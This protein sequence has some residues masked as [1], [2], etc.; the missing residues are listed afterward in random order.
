MFCLLRGHLRYNKAAYKKPTLP[1]SIFAFVP[2]CFLALLPLSR[3]SQVSSLASAGCAKRLQFLGFSDA[4]GHP[5]VSRRDAERNP[6]MPS[7]TQGCL[8]QL[9]D[10]SRHPWV[11]SIPEFHSGLPPSIPGFQ[12]SLGFTQGCLQAS[13]ASR[14]ASRHPSTHG[15]PQGCRQASLTSL[16]PRM[17][18]G[19]PPGIPGFQ[20]CLRASLFFFFLVFLVF[21]CSLISPPSYYPMF[22][23]VC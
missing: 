22:E 10:A 2:C 13:L 23:L 11:P 9:R 3:R 8:Q 20:G 21:F 15:C 18:P 12:A 14:D 1:P 17:P 5:W 16:D 6:G 4:S 19:M 7:K